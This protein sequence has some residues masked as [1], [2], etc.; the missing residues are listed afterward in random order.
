[1]L[2]KYITRAVNHV[3]YNTHVVISDEDFIKVMNEDPHTFDSIVNNSLDW[4]IL[5]GLILNAFSLH[6]VDKRWP[7][8]DEFREMSQIEFDAFNDEFQKGCVQHGFKYS[9]NTQE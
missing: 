7:T 3:R 8:A 4:D 6:I 2:N 5:E 9:K 1:M